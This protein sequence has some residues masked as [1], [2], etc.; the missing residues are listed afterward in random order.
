[1]TCTVMDI[2]I[3]YVDIKRVSVRITMH[4]MIHKLKFP[5]INTTASHPIP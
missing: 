3:A 5:F 1:M 4:F 2:T